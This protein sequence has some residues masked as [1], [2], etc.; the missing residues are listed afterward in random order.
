MAG[1]KESI[2]PRP[3]RKTKILFID[4]ERMPHKVGI[5]KNSP[6]IILFHATTYQSALICFRIMPRFDEVYFDH[7]LGEEKT[8]Y[9]LI[10]E[11]YAELPNKFPRKVFVHSDN[12]VGAVNIECYANSIFKDRGQERKAIRLVLPPGEK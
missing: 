2:L 3:P 11:M 8:G 1:K 10:K 5:D 12:P 4:D 7:D 9:D 6:N